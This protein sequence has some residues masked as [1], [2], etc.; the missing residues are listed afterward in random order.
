MAAFNDNRVRVA[1]PGRKPSQ[2]DFVLLW[3]QRERRL[4]HNHALDWALARARELR[5][6]LVVYEELTLDLPW[7]NLRHG[8]FLLEGMRDN[9]D[10]AEARGFLYWPY[11]QTRRSQ[12]SPLTGLAQRAAIVVTDDF[13]VAPVPE[14]TKRLADRID[15]P[16]LAIDGNG[17]VPLALLGAPPPVAR[18]LRPRLHRA[19]LEA[20]KHRA[21]KAPEGDDHAALDPP[22]SLWDPAD[23]ESTLATLPVDRSVPAAPLRGGARAARARLGYFVAHKLDGYAKHHSKPLPPDDAF[24]S[25][26]SPY[27]HAGHIAIAEVTEAV[28]AATGGTSTRR[29]VADA[30]GDKARFFGSDA[31][32]NAFLDEALVWRDLCHLFLWHRREDVP[33]LTRALPDWAWATL[34]AHRRDRRRF[35]YSFDEWERGETHD[36]LWNAAQR[37][38]ALTG[39]LHGYLRMLWGKKVLEWSASPEEAY[40]TLLTLNDKYALDGSDPC[41]YGNILWCFGLFD[42]PWFPERPVLG[43]VRY[44]T[45]ES[46][47]RKFSLGAYRRY[48]EGI[49]REEGEGGAKGEGR[50]AKGE[51]QGRGARARGTGKGKGKGAGRGRGRCGGREG[52]GGRA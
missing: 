8:R 37:E 1:S 44:M 19:L 48:V 52:A 21:S 38:L 46:T 51:G 6:P 40:E 20:W 15:A 45:S 24:T 30:A 7:P 5:I 32:A 39:R 35:V 31:N 17:L 26:L 41:S 2:G 36:A 3:M 33:S 42:R 18:S 11:V 22:F 16:V 4:S 43:R 14:K 10:N 49:G 13:P 47:A 34:E 23:L 29:F 12:K 9:A 27:L 25:G 50:R 28:L